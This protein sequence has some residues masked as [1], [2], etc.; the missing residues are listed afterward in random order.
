MRGGLYE[1]NGDVKRRREG[2]SLGDI[3]KFA[4]RIT[5]FGAAIFVV[6]AYWPDNW[7]ERLIN[8][9]EWLRYR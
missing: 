4:L 7:Q 8:F 6:I 9:L 1:F 2:R 5:A 3:I